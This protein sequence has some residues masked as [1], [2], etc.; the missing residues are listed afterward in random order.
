MPP[1]WNVRIVNCVPGSPML[2]AAMDADRL[3]VDNRLESRQGDAVAE[4]ADAAPCLASQ[5]GAHRHARDSGLT[6]LA[7][8]LIRDRV[9]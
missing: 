5:R 1:V 8:D 9:A 4:A 7:D 2:C 6:D 3:A